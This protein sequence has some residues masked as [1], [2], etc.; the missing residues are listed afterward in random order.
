MNN[1]LGCQESGL[2]E[3]RAQAR[4]TALVME[5]YEEPDLPQKILGRFNLLE[6]LAQNELGETFLLSEKLGGKKFI[7]KSFRYSNET[8]SESELLNGLVHKG[9]PRFEPKITY[10]NV[11][12]TLREFIDGVSLEEYV[13]QH[14]YLDEATATAIFTELC[15]I[16]DLLHS[17]PVPIIHRDIKP[18]NII[19]NPMDNSVT[20]ID[21][22]IS[23]KYN[24]NASNDTTVFATPEFAAPEQYGF[25]QTDTRT[26]VYS[27]GVVYR[28][29]LT[30]STK[31]EISNAKV[32]RVTKKCTQF[33]PSS[34]YQN[35]GA[36]KKVLSGHTKRTL[37][38]LRFAAVLIFGIM[39]AGAYTIYSQSEI[40]FTFEE[41]LIEAAVR[42]A[43][44]LGDNQ[45]ITYEAL[46]SVTEIIIIGMYV[47]NTG[48]E[49]NEYST[50]MGTIESL[51][52][53]K[54]MP[55]LRALQL[56]HQPFTDIS[57]LV[58]NT[59]LYCVNFHFIDI[60]DISPLVLLPN[61]YRLRFESV[62]VEDW[63]DIEYM[64][65]LGNFFVRVAYSNNSNIKR[66]SD[67]GDI[68]NV[69]L[70]EIAHCNVF[71]SLEGIQDIPGLIA[72][73][74]F[75]TAVQDFS[76]LNDEYALPRLMELWI[77]ADMEQYLYTLMRDGVEVIFK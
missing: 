74:I 8:F 45:R 48:F 75:D 35:A 64:D 11:V 24:A 73:Y 47:S 30:G 43:L 25:A 67:L 56:G 9:L 77:S 41:P 14:G 61:L 53:L 12:F 19:I 3:T 65:N 22:G 52:D 42:L 15:D 2:Y 69:Y 10:G 18:T 50:Q 54:Y 32:A 70:L 36:I 31:A 40:Y 17:Q 66:I 23:R 1:P 21:F 44:N 33:A 29:M 55:N 16:V 46:E 6:L 20:L 26:D 76:L 60:S 5:T 13:I 57:S 62:L 71:Y 37:N 68:S 49:Y 4:F 63:S 27:L 39:F 28:Y 34:R 59:E 72:L 7:L 38:I 58:Y 51:S